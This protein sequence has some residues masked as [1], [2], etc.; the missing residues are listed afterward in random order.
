M[1][2]LLYSKTVDGLSPM[3][4][5]IIFCSIKICYISSNKEILNWPSQYPVGRNTHLQYVLKMPYQDKQDILPRHFADVQ[6][7]S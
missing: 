5:S 3:G 6:N 7:I 2:F 1:A 4:P